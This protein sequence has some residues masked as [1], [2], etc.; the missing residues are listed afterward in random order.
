MF[1]LP[2][3]RRKSP[4]SSLVP[5]VQDVLDL[6]GKSYRQQA[7]R[8]FFFTNIDRIEAFRRNESTN[9]TIWS[10]EAKRSLEIE[11]SYDVQNLSLISSNP[12]T[13]EDWLIITASYSRLELPEELTCS[14]FITKHR[15]PEILTLGLA[16]NMGKNIGVQSKHRWFSTLPL[17]ISNNFPLHVNASFILAE[18]RRSIRFDDDGNANPESKYNRWLLSELI[19]KVYSNLLNRISVNNARYWP[20]VGPKGAHLSSTVTDALYSQH[21]KSSN[22][23]PFVDVSGRRVSFKDVIL[24]HKDKIQQRI[25]EIVRMLRPNDVVEFSGYIGDRLLDEKIQGLR[26]SHLHRAILDNLTAFTSAFNQ[27]SLTIRHLN[28]LTS[29]LLDKSK[30]G[31]VSNIIGIPILP[32]RDG[33]LGTVD[34][35]TGK[36]P[37]IWGPEQT[38][39]L[40]R[41][42][43]AIDRIIEPNFDAESSK[44]LENDGLNVRRPGGAEIAELIRQHY[45]EDDICELSVSDADRVDE[46]WCSSEHLPIDYTAIRHVALV[47][48]VPWRGSQ[49]RYLSIARCSELD[50]F[51]EPELHQVIVK[52]LKRLGAIFIRLQSLHKNLR[53][54]LSESLGSFNPRQVL[55]FFKSLARSKH[56][57][58]HPIDQDR[59]LVAEQLRQWL[60]ADPVD[61]VNL[62]VAKSLRIWPIHRRGSLSELTSASELEMLPRECT[63]EV[64]EPFL[65]YH[66]PFIGYTAALRNLGVEP[67]SLRELTGHLI[68]KQNQTVTDLELPLLVSVIGTII[69]NASMRSDIRDILVP[70]STRRLRNARD[71]YARSVPLFAAAF[72]NRPQLLIHESLAGVENHL[73]SF[74]LHLHIDSATFRE[75]AQAIHH[76]SRRQGMPQRPG[77]ELAFR[78]YCEN[79]P[80]LT[81]SGN[82]STWHLLEDIRFIPRA[83]ARSTRHTFP[84]DDV[85]IVPLPSVVSPAETLRPEHEAVAWTQRALPQ[86]PPN[87]FE[88]LYIARPAFGVP[89]TEEVVSISPTAHLGQTTHIYTSSEGATPHSSVSYC[90][91]PPRRSPAARRYHP[92]L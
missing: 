33:D 69:D 38:N 73:A 83:Q 41:L 39:R 57:N 74:G 23:H 92:H 61:S 58:L 13:K 63:I 43:P 6:L 35:Y 22:C 36:S 37:Y 53:G 47:A 90:P 72:S 77:A 15:I 45:P 79:L 71:L 12:R 66:H 70:D 78:C 85:D 20:E 29:F 44:L 9:D 88:R 82:D 60:F 48:T 2:L 30:G 14:D 24:L 4:L 87:G 56:I 19:P 21:I 10:Y 34:K 68:L 51:P 32:L 46:L 25:I 75:C 67:M 62:V 84:T 26:P 11:E 59:D 80:V 5:K 1:R 28:A 31:G 55:A 42:F 64:F 3:R 8:S 7:R 27:Q 76:D 49:T 18:D 81:S 89:S 16:A 91:Y 54:E 17:P 65:S 50:V 40:T 86:I 52:H